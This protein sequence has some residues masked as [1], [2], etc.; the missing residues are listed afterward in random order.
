V[1]LTTEGL[2]QKVFIAGILLWKGSVFLGFLVHQNLG[3]KGPKIVFFIIGVLLLQDV[4][5][6]KLT[7]KG[8]RIKFFIARIMLFR[9]FNV[10]YFVLM[11]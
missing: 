6:L 2:R 11:R 10:S 3:L 9:G 5:I 7:T 8:L 1:K 4:F